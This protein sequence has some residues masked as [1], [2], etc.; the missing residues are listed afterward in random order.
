[1]THARRATATSQM[2]SA[3]H[4]RRPQRDRGAGAQPTFQRLS[5]QHTGQ[6]RKVLVLTGGGGNGSAQ[7]AAVA[8]LMESGWS[9]DLIVGT[10]IGAWNGAILASNPT[11]E[12]ARALVDLWDNG[13]FSQ[14]ARPQITQA[15]LAA[16]GR[17]PSFL[18]GAG[19]QRVA[20]AAG[21]EA[22]TFGDL[23]CP[24]LCN[25]VD[26]ATMT[27]HTFGQEGDH[28]LAVLTAVRASSALQPIFPPITY[29]GVTYTDGGM[30]DNSGLSNLLGALGRGAEPTDIVI[31]DAA[32]APH[33]VHGGPLQSSV[34]A[35]GATFHAQL[36]RGVHDALDAGHSVVSVN[37]G[38]NHSIFDFSSASDGV[39]V[40]T[41]IG[42][43]LV[44][45]LPPTFAAWPKRSLI[46]KVGN[47]VEQLVAVRHA[48]SPELG[49]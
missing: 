33:M 45:G 9:P 28:G 31:I 39:R 13:T 26:S 22:L 18:G 23:T 14:L 36:A 42:R 20:A 12:G 5:E 24:L 6:R 2:S 17:R 49:A 27:S 29:N 47:T 16:L 19:A 41:A 10:S 44:S 48:K 21:I 30:V 37:V 43:R 40:G 3:L 4:E 34:A 32:P 46:S 38:G 11:A 15:A 7:A 1:M 35:L 8:V 25:A